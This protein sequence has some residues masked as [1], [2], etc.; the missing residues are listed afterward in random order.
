MQIPN[1]EPEDLIMGWQSAVRQAWEEH[2]RSRDLG[3]GTIRSIGV[4]R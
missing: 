1:Y 3:L 4:R 2:E